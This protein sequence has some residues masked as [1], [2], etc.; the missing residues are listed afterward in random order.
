MADDP[1]R[2]LGIDKSASA[3]DVRDAYRR[4]AKEHHPDHSGGDCCRFRQVQEAYEEICDSRRGQGCS[5]SVTKAPSRRP[6]PDL[7]R[8]VTPG[9]RRATRHVEP[10][11]PAPLTERR[12]ARRRDPFDEVFE[13][14]WRAFEEI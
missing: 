6:R 11:E 8:D 13:R 2:T 5:I 10:L 14:L 9:K 12:F 1:Y 7:F 3:G 4:L